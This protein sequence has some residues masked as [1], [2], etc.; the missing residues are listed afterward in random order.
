[1]ESV[2]SKNKLSLSTQIGLFAI[3]LELLGV[4]LAIFGIFYA[5]ILMAHAVLGLT[6]LIYENRNELKINRN[7]LAVSMMSVGFILLFSIFTA[8]TIFSGRDQGSYSEAAIRLSQNHKLE[9]STPASQE[10]FK[11]YGP[12]EALN[13]PGFNYVQ[14]GS[15]VTHFPLG[16]I[17]WLAIFYSIFGLNGL[18]IAN[19]V[20]LFIFLISFYLLARCYLKPLPA[21]TSYFL[22]LT[23]FIFSWFFKFTLSE[24][25]ALAIVFFGLLQFVLY[26]KNSEKL[27]LYS[28]LFAFFVLL[29]TKIEGLAFLAML[30]VILYIKNKKNT[31]HL[32]LR[33]SDS[34]RGNP[35]VY[36][37]KNRD[38]L[39]EVQHRCR[40]ASLHFVALAM[41]KVCKN[42][43][44]I[45]V[46]ATLAIVYFW[47][48]FQNFAYYK[49]FAKGLLHSFLPGS[50]AT[51][52]APLSF[53]Q[54]F[55]YTFE[56]MNVYGLTVYIIIGIMAF[57]YFLKKKK[58]DLLMPFFIVLPSFIYLLQPSVSADHPWM[59]RRFV[60]SVIPICI[61][62]SVIFLDSYF[63]KKYLFYILCSLLL[64]SN[65]IIFIPYLTISENKDMLG[66]IQSLS[67]NFKDNDLVLVDQ[68][69]TGDGF[70][71]MTGPMNFLYNKQAVYFINPA[72][73]DKID[74]SKFSH[75]Y[76][77]I[78]D[79]NLSLYENS[80]LISRLNLAKDYQIETN[81]LDTRLGKKSELASQPIEL[82][83][84]QNVTTYGKIYILK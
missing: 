32:S 65:L 53:F 47:N 40:Q 33:G 15:L 75:I 5:F 73:I 4:I 43:K 12:G 81:R 29:F 41:T 3:S 50:V 24:N 1:M 58:Y 37:I 44:F 23:S 74:R 67:Q 77:I 82:P 22:L 70:A 83:V 8:P 17:S 6:Y 38:C 28:S 66:Q 78:P 49:I 56:I 7:F 27:Y 46:S 14:N 26:I 31:A 16:Y 55:Y 51:S 54:S 19:A 25:L 68:K 10:F 35:F 18:V 11:I 20:S 13:F 34:D 39:P 60:F 84:N 64:L 48:I 62:Y 52:E 71:M 21:L 42:K 45:A 9:F 36:L 59:L 69:A 30:L 63:K 61:L 72:D 79:D 76:F 2:F 80:G 57:A